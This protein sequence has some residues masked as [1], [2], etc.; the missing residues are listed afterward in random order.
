ME[1]VL[2][3]KD[4]GLRQL[5]RHRIR[6]MAQFRLRKHSSRH[7]WRVTADSLGQNPFTSDINEPLWKLRDGEMLSLRAVAAEILRPFR[8]RIREIS[9]S[10]TLDHIAAV[11]AGDARSLLDFQKRPDAYDDIGH[12]IDWARR[13]MRG[14]PRSRYEK[15]VH[16]LIAREPVR[17]GGKRY[18]VDRMVGWYQ[19]EFREVGTKRRRIFNLD[20][21]VK[22]S[23]ATRPAPATGSPKRKPAAKRRVKSEE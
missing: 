10:Y 17:I 1:A 6:R 15:V 12:R 19:V 5:E 8:G 14:W 3:W 7:G 23:A 16:R 21:L 22:L 18:Q 4:F 11:F 9:D 13:K 20:E 2:R